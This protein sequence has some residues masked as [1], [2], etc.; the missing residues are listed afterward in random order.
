MVFHKEFIKIVEASLY[1]TTYFACTCNKNQMPSI[2]PVYPCKTAFETFAHPDNVRCILL[3]WYHDV[4]TPCAAQINH[5]G[6]NS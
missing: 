2:Q 5:K 1:M 6:I 4:S 3:V